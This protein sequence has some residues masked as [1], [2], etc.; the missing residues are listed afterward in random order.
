MFWN[1]NKQLYITRKIYDF[2]A[3]HKVSSNNVLHL[4]TQQHNNTTIFMQRRIEPFWCLQLNYAPAVL[5][6]DRYDMHTNIQHFYFIPSTIFGTLLVCFFTLY[7]SWFTKLTQ[8]RLYL[9]FW[10]QNFKIYCRWIDKV[11]F[12]NHS[13]GQPQPSVTSDRNIITC[14]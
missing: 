3:V 10:D 5:N 9:E 14:S 1:F 13:N 8:I 12:L 7:Y 11:W 6:L 2:T 4:I